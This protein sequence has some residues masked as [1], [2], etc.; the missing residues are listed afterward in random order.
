MEHVSIILRKNASIK[1]INRRKVFLGLKA[2][3][4]KP[5]PEFRTKDTHRGLIVHF[6]IQGLLR[7][8]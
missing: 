6:V 7:V 3:L 5:V 1:E 8:S 2:F 4:F